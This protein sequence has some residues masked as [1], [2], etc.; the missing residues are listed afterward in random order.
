MTHYFTDQKELYVFDKQH[1]L[2]GKL[3]LSMEIN[4][5]GNHKKGPV[6][7][8]VRFAMSFTPDERY[9]EIG[10]EDG[11]VNWVSYQRDFEN[12][13]DRDSYV[14]TFFREISC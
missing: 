7:V 5:R 13:T 3:R 2:E 1:R 6:P 9:Q 4:I 12:Q 14:K 8:T 10:P 11:E